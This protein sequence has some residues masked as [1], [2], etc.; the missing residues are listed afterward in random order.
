MRR[1]DLIIIGTGSGN[2]ILTPEF[3]SWDVAIVER[4][5]F[6]GTCLNR[7]CVPS[8]ML[9]HAAD[10]A[11]AVRTSGHLGVDALVEKV[12]WSDIVD[13]VFGWIDPIADGGE[14][15]RHRL[16]NVTVY[17]EDA[18]FVDPKILQVGDEQITADQIVIAAGAR[19]FVPE[20]PGLDTV[21]WHT[22][23]SIM[24]IN[25]FPE[26]LVV[27]G[28]GYIAAEMA[29]V[30]DGLG[31]QVTI[32]NRS[33][34]MLRG[35]DS[36]VRHAFTELSK[37]RFDVALNA[38]I[39][40]VRP[41]PGG[42]IA[43]EYKADDDTFHVEADA[44]LVATGRIPNSTQLDVEACG[45]AIDGDGYVPTD[46]HLRTN[47]EGVWALGDIRNPLQLKHAAN[48]DARAITHNLL[49]PDDLVSVDLGITPHAVFT[50]PQVASIGANE[51]D[52]EEAG[53]PYK[54]SIR[55]YGDTAYGWALNDTTS[56]CK[57]L[58]DPETR[59]VLGAHIM[60]PQ[61]STLI[62]Q[63]VQGMRFGQTV[64]E[65]ATQQ[66]YIH[67]ALPEVIEQALLEL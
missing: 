56:F 27:M 40:E 34:Y 11:Y 10:T 18:R 14:A 52:L 43:V 1:F 15:Y 30:F 35:E 60:G 17:K 5:V 16:E 48:A 29:H 20:I 63:L 32:L 59:L 49:N 8:K 36:D 58:A 51:Q 13:R 42:A 21:D 38:Y 4:D 26:R 53:T 54:C 24:R 64:D 62:Q 9:V 33:S 50:N 41:A 25:E 55:P 45:V 44:F 57:I 31:S 2:T 19:A 28:A 46:Q 47:V 37:H 6:G 23:D 3:D 12:R 22:S 65:M 67:P 7:G 66:Y 39:T 61:A